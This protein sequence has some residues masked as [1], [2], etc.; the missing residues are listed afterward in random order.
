MRLCAHPQ[1]EVLVLAW[2]LKAARMGYFTKDEWLDGMNTLGYISL[3]A[4]ILAEAG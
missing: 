2:K 1:I 3:P 4:P